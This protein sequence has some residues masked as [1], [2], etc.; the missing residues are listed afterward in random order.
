MEDLAQLRPVADTPD[1]HPP[2][3]GDLGERAEDGARGQHGGGD[4]HAAGGGADHRRDALGELL[5]A[6]G[7]EPRP[8]AHAVAEVPPWRVEGAAVLDAAALPEVLEV[9]RVG[10]CDLGRADLD[11]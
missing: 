7:G 10:R 4:P 5:A 3:R 6:A 9:A 2:L 11:E 8:G 1:V